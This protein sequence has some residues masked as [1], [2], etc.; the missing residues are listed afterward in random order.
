MRFVERLARNERVRRSLPDKGRLHIDRQLPFLCVYRQPPNHV[1][2]GT[3]RLVQGEASYL[4]APGGSKFRHGIS[5]LVRNIQHACR[6]N[7][8]HF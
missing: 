7:L 6:M 5:K 2:A 8:G 3:E 1:D 4:I